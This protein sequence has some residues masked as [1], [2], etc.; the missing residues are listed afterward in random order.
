MAGVVMLYELELFMISALPVFLIGLY[1]YKKDKNKEPVKLLI[2]LFFGGLGSCVLV[3]IFSVILYFIS[4]HI[5][6]DGT[7]LSLIKLIIHVFVGVALV[8]EFCKWIMVY[9]ISYDDIE[10]DE[11]YDAIIYCVFVSL[12]FACFEN[13]LYVYQNGVITGILRALLAVPGHACAGILMGYYFGLSKISELNG[14][15][16]LKIKNLILSIVVPTIVHGIYDYCLLTGML[17]FIA[18]FL[19]FIIFLYVYALKKVKY[20]SSIDRK[21]KY[22]DNYCPICGCAVNSNFC[23]ICGRKND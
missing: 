20:V 13:L 11:F 2:K 6:G 17:F 14:R 12:G 5:F 8:E 9:M 1:I 4:P 15:K 21:M 7:E 18:L 23:P 16:D 19:I 22:K 10:F 3:I